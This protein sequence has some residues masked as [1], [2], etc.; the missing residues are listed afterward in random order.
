MPYR[1]IA[2]AWEAFHRDGVTS[3]VVRPAVLASWQ[4]SRQHSIAA[5]RSGAPLLSEAELFRR[6]R[7][8]MRLLAAARPAMEEAR[9]LLADASSMLILADPAGTI[10][11][12]EGDARAVD[13]G[14]EV[15]LQRGGLWCEAE[16]GTNAIGTALASGRPVQIHATEHFCAPVQRWTCA[17]APV[18]HPLEG[19]VIGAVDISGSTDTF[20]PQN[21]AHAVAL[22]H[23]IEAVL[24]RRLEME[25]EQVLRHFLSKR[26]LWVSEE[27]IAFG[28]SG[29]LIYSTD[30]ALKEVARRSDRFVEDGRLAALRDTRPED[31]PTRVAAFLPGASVE[32]VREDGEE[33]GGVLVLHAPRRV[34]HSAKDTPREPETVFFDAIIGESKVMREAREKARRMAE[35]GLPILLEG[36]TGVGK[37][38]FARAIHGARL[39]CGPFVPLNCGGLPRELIASELFGYEKGAFT[40]A[41][42]AGKQGKVEAAN[43]GLLCLDEIGEMPLEL[44]SYLLR[45]LEDGVVYRVG[46]HT[47]RRVDLRLVSMTN[48]DLTGEVAAGRFRKDLFYRIAALRLRI[49]PLREREGDVLILMEHFGALAAARAD[50]PPPSFSEAARAALT[51]YEWPGNVRELRNMVDMLVAM[52]RGEG[53][54]DLADLPPEVCGTSARTSDAKDLKAVEEAAIRAAVE[55]CGGNLSRAARR[56]GIARSTLYMRLAASEGKGG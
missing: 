49:P 4:R 45:V 24:G 7:Q 48:R 53:E 15:K 41:D 36:E 6:R 18:R 33:I 21:L 9:N 23:Q 52:K 12:T 34:R 2:R 28:R 44:Q 16:I 1:E 29:T 17:A 20:N 47:G 32:I 11:E 56:L 31:W 5:D 30:R 40:G 8:N 43:G 14:Q 39:P 19:S 13:T 26:G 38:V 37:E 54:V 35:S 42:A 10:L 3:P 22:A 55:A 50:L 27:I 46:S 51:A 25:H